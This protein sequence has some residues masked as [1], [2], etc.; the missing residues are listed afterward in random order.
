MGA[1][2]V[3][4]ALLLAL[5]IALATGAAYGPA[6]RGGFVWDDEHH[7]TDLPVLRSPDGLR[8]I[9]MQPGAT[10][11]YYPLTFTVFRLQYHLW[12]LDPAGYHAVNVALHVLNAWLLLALLRRFRLRGAAFAAALFALHPV[13]AMSVAWITELKNVLS[14]CFALL[15]F[16]ACASALRLDSPQT[17]HRRAWYL[18][19][20]ACFAAA[21]LTK[22]ATALLPVALAL[23]TWLV[24]GRLDRR[25]V[26]A[27]AP[28]LVIGLALG[29]WTLWLERGFV[30]AS[31]GVFDLSPAQRVLHAGHAFWFYLGKL[32]WPHPLLFFYPLWQ[33]DPARAADWLAPV[34]VAALLAVL[35]LRRA[36]WSR[37]PLALAL[38]FLLSAPALVLVQVLFMMQYTPVALHWIY[39]GAPA[40]CAALG[41]AAGRW[42]ERR[43]RARV[44]LA[45]L[46]LVLLAGCGALTWREG[47][48]YRDAETLYRET[49]RR[50]PAC[51]IAAYNLGNARAA[52]QR[53][54][55]ALALYQQ[56]LESKPDY[57]V[58][59]VNYANAWVALGD[60]LRAMAEFR[61][62]LAEA[63]ATARAHH[64]LGLLLAQGGHAAEA[65][66]HLRRAVEL[67]PDDLD[68]HHNLGAV[69]AGEG[70]IDE[71]LGH[72][73]HV[74]EHA[75]GSVPDL[76]HLARFCADHGRADEARAL[77]ERVRQL[78]PGNP[79]ARAGLGEP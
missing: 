40:L 37:A 15:S 76:L 28:F 43:P 68:L 44:P 11:Q 75:P 5:L 18:A 23:A 58:A 1:S 35:W 66:V 19:A 61:R 39:F 25:D 12:G 6:L 45:A 9:W 53:W 73:R 60:P 49:L 74:V 62:V 38:Y 50:N 46:G 47:R 22:T 33:L 65:L 4:S 55:E 24:R 71:A 56:A 20:L 7:V 51:F 16:H 27:L 77:F 17:R 54:P 8:A 72:F 48:L 30:G 36:R 78:D 70:R 31:G 26:A 2:R 42:A 79:E 69:L 64:N 29:A 3:S 57:T 59:R 13:N 10:L 63:P 14:L 34:A 32:L 41:H 52:Q 21:L 67:E